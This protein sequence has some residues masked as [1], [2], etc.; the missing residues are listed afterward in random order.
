MV[1]NSISILITVL[2]GLQPGQWRTVC[3]RLMGFDTDNGIRKATTLFKGYLVQCRP[4]SFDTDNGI[5]RATTPAQLPLLLLEMIVSI[6]ITVLGG[7]QQD[8]GNRERRQFRV[9]IPIT[10]LGGLQ[11]ECASLFGRK[12]IVSIP[13]TVLG[14]LQH[15][16]L[17][18]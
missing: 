2:G 1:I 10:V 13:I 3:C 9:S 16:S 8:R 5:R 18:A 15:K 6:P 4:Q 14:G 17:R 11:P 12:E 7:L